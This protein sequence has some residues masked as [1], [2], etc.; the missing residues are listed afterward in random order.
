MVTS[1]THEQRKRLRDALINAFRDKSSLEQMLFFGLDK[2]L[3]AITGGTNLLQIVFHLIQT[4]EAEGWVSGL[5]RAARESNEGNL[6]LKQ[7]AEELVPNDGSISSPDS[8]QK[9][10]V[11]SN[12]SLTSNLTAQTVLIVTINDL[13]IKESW[14]RPDE[15]GQ[16]KGIN[17]IQRQ[18]EIDRIFQI[19]QA[20]QQQ[21]TMLAICGMAGSGKS[22]LA[23]L[24][25]NKYGGESYYP[26]GVLWAELGSRFIPEQEVKPILTRW[27][28]WA[29]GGYDVLLQNITQKPIDIK[30]TDVYKLLSGKGKML[31]VF[32]DVWKPEHLKPF[33]DALPREAN[34][35]VTT[36]EP[37]QIRDSSLHFRELEITCLSEDDALQ[38]LREYLP[39]LSVD[40]L[41]NL[42]SKFGYHPQAIAIVASQLQSK[43][44]QVEATQQLLEQREHTNQLES[45]WVAFD[46]NYKNLPDDTYRRCFR[47][48]GI[49]GEIDA[50][51][52]TEI[53]AALWNETTEIAITILEFLK[54]RVLINHVDGERWSMHS[55]LREFAQKLLR[56]TEDLNVAREYYIESIV[57][58]AYK[59]TAWLP[60]S[61]EIPHLLYVGSLLIANVEV[62]LSSEEISA[63]SRTSLKHV[64]WF[65]SR[66][67]NYLL[68]RP[69]MF[70]LSKRWIDVFIA[71]TKALDEQQDLAWG[72][73]IL[74]R[75]YILD[76]KFELALKQFQDVEQIGQK[77]QDITIIGYALDAQGNS[78]RLLNQIKEAIEVFKKGLEQVKESDYEDTQLQ[79]NLLTSLTGLYL[80]IHD[81]DKARDYLAQAENLATNTLHDDFL[82]ATIAQQLGILSLNQ[83]EPDKALEHF[84]NAQQILEKLNDERKIAENSI[85]FGWAYLYKG[86][87]E[88]AIKCFEYAKSSADVL[89]YPQLKALALN[90]IASINYAENKLDQSLKHLN[91]ALTFL[92]QHPN[93]TQEAQIHGLLGSV[94]YSMGQP[95]KALK[96]LQHALPLLKDV[97]DTTTSVNILYAIGLIYQE[98]DRIAEGLEYLEKSLPIIESMNNT[99]AEVTIFTWLAVLLRGSGNNRKAKTYFDRT[100]NIIEKI[101]NDIERATALTLTA[102]F[103]RFMGEIEKAYKD[104]RKVENLW[105]KLNNITKLSEVFVQLAEIAFHL[106]KFDETQEYLDKIFEL[107]KGSQESDNALILAQSYN[108]RGLLYLQSEKWDDAV[109][110]FNRSAS[111]NESIKNPGLQ[112]A[113]HSN[114]GWVRLITKQDIEAAYSNFEAALKIS[115]ENKIAPHTATV[116]SNLGYL[117]YLQGKNSR[118]SEY[119]QEAIKILE[120]EGLTTDSS[121]QSIYML[122]MIADEMGKMKPDT[123]P[124][125]SLNLLLQVVNW[126]GI[127]FII[128]ARKES[129]L[130]DEADSIL[131]QT[132]AEVS[133]QNNRV[134]LESILRFYRQ[135][136]LDCRSKN[137]SVLQRMQVEFSADVER[138]WAYLQ[139]AEQNY[140]IALTHINRFLEIKQSDT[141]A[142]IERGWIQR[143]L[144]C[145]SSALADFD[146][147]LRLNKS[148]YRAHQGKGVVH[149]EMGQ[150]TQAMADLTQAI[151]LQPKD[152]YSYHW[153]GTVYQTLKDF[154][155][156]LEDLNRAINLDPQTSSHRYWRALVLLENQKFQDALHNLNTVINLDEKA[157]PLLAFDYF[158]RGIVNELLGDTHAARYD[159][160]T[161]ITSTNSHLAL[162]SAPLYEIAFRNNIEQAIEQYCLLLKRPYAW[163]ILVSQ[164]RHLELLSCL[165]PNNIGYR[166]VHDL[167][168]TEKISQY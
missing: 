4:A 20:T 3:D 142:L 132:I 158:W 67:L 98:T 27:A 119:F 139:R 75:W 45:I 38:L 29:Y 147:V 120:D 11:Q 77:Y 57:R 83:S 87:H 64:G 15:L 128:Q 105:I 18:A 112:I 47:L 14:K 88:T 159:W 163:H 33:L 136:L 125:E 65:L 85:N 156:T 157:A 17:A 53:A 145:M 162:W 54:T 50:D 70:S 55:L 123:I 5:I 96:N 22:T 32:D 35:L 71:I 74:G 117:S 37:S 138:W 49:L 124:Q 110:M 78:L 39:K 28:G 114:L 68:L 126:D 60:N 113:T 164:I 104:L 2:N 44:S 108:L 93:R 94:Y 76:E 52:S 8:S 97:Q 118:A 24:Y 9:Q 25:V 1:L 73:Y 133:R 21:T 130:T 155:H 42:A 19:L 23:S 161:G 69:G 62:V 13:S 91:E 79:A 12:S 153:R 160:E 40:L 141:D 121:N 16:R 166:K 148:E 131:E 127:L 90:G 58:L 63:E 109:A 106:S 129:L 31:V 7:I 41:R 99:G 26:G 10:S 151:N 168:K 122:R 43:V 152:A 115:K 150:T 82:L 165:Y 111:I 59:S 140:N 84:Q 107:A 81:Q 137:I 30:A 95:D 48:L 66:A 89:P 86:D 154:E 6:F 101:K 36:R 51:F 144:G 143:G 100:E 46:S 167:L 149:F 102:Q 61:L 134:G 80:V 135:L 146:H 92:S 56:E 34:I 72:L 103:Y 116:L